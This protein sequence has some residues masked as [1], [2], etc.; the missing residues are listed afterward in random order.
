M[1]PR[2]GGLQ[3]PILRTF[4]KFLAASLI[5]VIRIGT[6]AVLKTRQMMAHLGFARGINNPA[7]F[8]NTVGP[9][10]PAQVMIE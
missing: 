6:G 1:V 9:G 2:Y 10:Q 4:V 5:T 8:L 7:A 3:E